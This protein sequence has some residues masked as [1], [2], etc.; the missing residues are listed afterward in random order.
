MNK[1]DYVL[2]NIWRMNKKEINNFNIKK[3]TNKKAYVSIVNSFLK[4][5]GLS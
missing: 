2:H 1:N 3:N 5:Y 4:K